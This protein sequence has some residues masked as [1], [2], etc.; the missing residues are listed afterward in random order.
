MCLNSESTTGHSYEHRKRC[1]PGKS[2]FYGN[3]P[4]KDHLIQIQI[5][6]ILQRATVKAKQKCSIENLL[7]FIIFAGK[8]CKNVLVKT[9]KINT[10]RQRKL[11]FG[12]R[13]MKNYV[14]KSGL[15]LLRFIPTIEVTM[16]IAL[17]T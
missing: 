8:I 9:G 14:E 1:L 10:L 15:F 16:A 7:L 5:Y 3:H 17:A 6:S 4:A 2:I 11:A 12:N 13:N